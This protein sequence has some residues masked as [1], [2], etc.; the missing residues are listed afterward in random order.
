MVYVN[1]TDIYGKALAT[2]MRPMWRRH[3]G[4][5]RTIAALYS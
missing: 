3:S 4:S 1:I 2:Q 5:F